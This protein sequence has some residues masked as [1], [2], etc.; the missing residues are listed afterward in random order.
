M[1]ITYLGHASFKIKS[2]SGAVIIIDPF[3]PE[4]VGLPFPKD[5]ADVLIVSHNDP[6]HNNISAV[7][8]PVTRLSTF[9]VDKEGEYEIGGI[10][11]ATY[12]TFH[13]GSEGQQRGKNLVN[14]IRIDGITLCHL[15]DLGHELTDT[16]IEKIGVI[17][18]LMA[19]VGGEVALD[20]EKM[21]KLIRDISPSYV[22]PMHYKEP[23]HKGDF[24]NMPGI[25][26]FTEKNKYQMAGDPVHKIKIDEGSLPDETQILMMN[27]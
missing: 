7:T 22:I 2:K 21:A 15:G 12:K 18:V 27:A 20:A 9:V 6:G 3:S 24:V 1:E 11:I 13:D 19:R 14:V 16:L 26:V 5:V 23:G 17:D 8:G 10:E 4:I 25:E